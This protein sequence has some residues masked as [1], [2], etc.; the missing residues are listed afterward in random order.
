MA[1]IK[2]SKRDIR[3]SY[4]RHL[5][6]QTRKGRMRGGIRRAKLAIDTGAENAGQAI[7]EALS[8]IDKAASSG[9]IHPNAAARRKSR[10]ARRA[11]AAAATAT[12]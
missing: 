8:V 3:K 1:N 5:R 9:A 10:L 4:E 12:A 7:R 2:S 11:N 6:N